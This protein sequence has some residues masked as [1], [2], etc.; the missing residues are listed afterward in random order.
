MT[1]S[2]SE[3]WETIADEIR[4]DNDRLL[5]NAFGHKNLDVYWWHSMIVEKICVDCIVYHPNVAFSMPH[6]PLFYLGFKRNQSQMLPG[7][8]FNCFG[9]S[10]AVAVYSVVSLL[11]L[12]PYQV[13][14]TLTSVCSHLSD[15]SPGLHQ[16]PK[17]YVFRRRVEICTWRSIIIA[18]AI[19]S[20][21]LK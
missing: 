16:S 15:Y 1:F 3:I 11:C 19:T 4:K 17:L 9:R 2:T 20:S 21:R 5:K 7:I 6:Q 14:H 13:N 8:E 10:G 12:L 18:L